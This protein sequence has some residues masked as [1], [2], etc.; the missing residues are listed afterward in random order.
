MELKSMY[1]EKS[2]REGKDKTQTGGK[3]S[4][5]TPG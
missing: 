2:L 5:N 4:Q 1:Y 3:Y